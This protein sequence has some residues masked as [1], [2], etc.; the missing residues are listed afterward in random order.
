MVHARRS[1]TSELYRRRGV[2]GDLGFCPVRKAIAK[3]AKNAKDAKKSDELK[4]LCSR[5]PLAS[6]ASSALLALNRK[7]K[8]RSLGRDAQATE[9]INI[10][11]SRRF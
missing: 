2:T 4:S 5:I 3:S 8:T 9:K 7:A 1:A 10:R 11:S 6:L